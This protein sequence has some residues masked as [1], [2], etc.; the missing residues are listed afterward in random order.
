[1]R[2]LRKME[3]AGSQWQCAK[4][5]VFMLHPIVGLRQQQGCCSI[6]PSLG[7]LSGLSAHSQGCIKQRGSWEHG[8]VPN[9]HWRMPDKAGE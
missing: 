4:K 3:L 9:L 1:M 8:N 2:A 7:R 5:R 6:S